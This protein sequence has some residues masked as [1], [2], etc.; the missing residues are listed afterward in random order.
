MIFLKTFYTEGQ[1]KWEKKG[2]AFSQAHSMHLPKPFV[3]APGGAFTYK[4]K[5]EKQRHAKMLTLN[6]RAL[7][8]LL[9]DTS[10]FQR[11]TRL[12]PP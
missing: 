9:E 12:R 11:K 7:K 2:A 5:R 1:G 3:P 8:G 10:T 6:L 4:C